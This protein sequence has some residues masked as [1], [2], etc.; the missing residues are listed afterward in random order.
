MIS[1]V[2]DLWITH[3]EESQLPY[4]KDTKGALWRDPHDKELR[5]PEPHKGAIVEMSP[6]V[7]IKPSDDS[8]A[9]ANILGHNLM[10]DPETDG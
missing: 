8:A 5:P 7:S 10:R 2:L 9:S 3:P 4:Y 6:P 1:T